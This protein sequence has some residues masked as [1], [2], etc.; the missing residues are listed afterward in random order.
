MGCAICDGPVERGKKLCEACRVR[1]A[2][3]KAAETPSGD[4]LL[5]PDGTPMPTPAAAPQP[6]VRLLPDGTP[7]P[8][9]TLEAPFQPAAPPAADAPHITFPSEEAVMAGTPPEPAV[10]HVSF[11]G[12]PAPG[13]APIAIH[14]AASSLAWLTP[15]RMK[16]II[17]ICL[18]IVLIAVLIAWHPWQHRYVPPPRV[19]AIDVE[20]S[21]Q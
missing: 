3:P 9:S 11:S 14:E 17:G 4:V 12:Q 21:G 18:G 6:D 20:D 10:P 16:L 13:A 2:A 15:A 5:M 8:V 1:L 7:V 19:E